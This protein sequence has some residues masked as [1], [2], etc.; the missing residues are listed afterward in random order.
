MKS[1]IKVCFICL[2]S[3]ISVS[4][5]YAVT[6]AGNQQSSAVSTKAANSYL[7]G[8]LN[9]R[10]ENGRLDTSVGEYQLGA[11]VKV[12]DQRPAAQ[13]FKVPAKASI[14]L[15]LKAGR[16]VGVIIYCAFWFSLLFLII[17]FR[18]NSSFNA[19]TAAGCWLFFLIVIPAILNV[20]VTI[21]YPLN[22]ATLA[23][24]TRRTGVENEDDEEECKE[25]IME[26]LAHKPDLIGSDSLLKNNMIPKTYAAFTTLK[27]INSQKEVS[28]YNAQVVK[29]NQWTSQFYWLSPA[30]NMQGVL[31]DIAE[32]DLNTFLRFQ[33]ALTDFH[34]NITDFYFQKLFW[35]KP[36][37]LKDYSQLPTFNMKR[38]ELDRWYI[39]WLDLV[40]I[41]LSTTLLFLFGFIK[42]KGAK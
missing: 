28:H 42:M 35:D 31:A 8:S 29:R 26:F 11:G 37:V 30:V 3:L 38:S 21:K 13:W 4:S 15:E 10:Y 41:T 2:C 22:S 20:I 25:V 17:S 24:L 27:D 36:I 14:Q 33:D 40:K 18:K 32:T 6:A 34:G 5:V 23:G 16:L 1:L 19:I 9:G 39:V 12:D 7:T